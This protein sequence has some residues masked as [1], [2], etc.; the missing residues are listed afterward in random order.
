LRGSVLVCPIN[1]AGA[2]NN[3]FRYCL[4]Y[5]IMI[6]SRPTLSLRSHLKI[7]QQEQ[8]SPVSP[9]LILRSHL[10]PELTLRSS[11]NPDSYSDRTLK[12]NN[13]PRS[14]VSPELILRS[15]HL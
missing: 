7:K 13:K 1:L 10:N 9:E 2:A 3:R 6:V 5:G 11:L 14:P 8:R 12:S 15:P 4:G